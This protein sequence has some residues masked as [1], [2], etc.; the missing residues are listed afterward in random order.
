[1]EGPRDF[2]PYNKEFVKTI[3]VKARAHWILH[4]KFYSVAKEV[5]ALKRFQFKCSCEPKANSLIILLRLKSD[6]I[7]FLKTLGNNMISIL[8]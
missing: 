1:M 2:V 8:K 3:F 7:L 6:T 5:A 4:F